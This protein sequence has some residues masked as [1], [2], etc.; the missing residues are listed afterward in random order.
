MTTRA[1]W[2]VVA[3][4]TSIFLGGAGWVYF[5]WQDSSEISALV[6]TQELPGATADIFTPIP[7]TLSLDSRKVALGGQLFSDPRLSG[8][9]SVSC[10]HCHNL[11]TGGVDR[12]PH[13]RGI[14]GKEGGINAPT[15][16][17]SG[18][19][20]RQFWDGRAETLEDQIDGPLQ[21]PIEM[22]STW[23]QALAA[24][25]EDP[26]YNAAFKAIYNDGVQPH[27]VKDAIATFERSLITPDSRF[28]RFLRGDQ[29][30]LNEEEKAG[31]ELFKQIG[32]TSC[33]QGINIGGNLYQKLGIMEDYFAVRGHITESDFGRF[34]VTKREQDRYYF[35]VPSLRNVALTPP[36]LHD[37]SLPTLEEVVQV[38]ARFQLGQKL[39][40][41]DVA[42]I[43]A[44][45]R[46]LTGEY[47][48][49]PLE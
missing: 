39:K 25:V 14:G 44:F 9:G 43:V 16:F 36:Y 42:R 35:K 18:F 26:Q 23:P 7:L 12:M 20:F 32:C 34:N 29:T 38:M 19:N 17:N 4:L 33:H 31:Y 8:D 6:A 47:A 24:I 1:T 11:D 10:A 40:A 15:V 21:N 27:N 30:A 5:D 2:I 48:G 37:G 28:D 46:T 41:G 49:K 45:L 13:S 3:S 22:A